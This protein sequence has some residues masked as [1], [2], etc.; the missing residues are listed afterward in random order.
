MRS[1]VMVLFVLILAVVAYE[2]FKP[3]AMVPG[4]TVVAQ[5]ALHE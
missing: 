2:T 4:V 3:Q 5:S 1:F